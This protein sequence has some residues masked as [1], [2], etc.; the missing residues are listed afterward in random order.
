MGC[1]RGVQA[2]GSPNFSLKR[3]TTWSMV[4]SWVS[5][6]GHHGL[7]HS[8]GWHNLVLDPLVRFH[9]AGESSGFTMPRV[10]RVD[11]SPTGIPSVSQGPRALV[12]P[13]QNCLQAC[14]GF[15][16]SLPDFHLGWWELQHLFQVGAFAATLQPSCSFL[17]AFQICLIF[18]GVG[19][20][21]ECCEIPTVS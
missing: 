3:S 20:G 14:P 4:A 5:F 18:T 13:A 16:H 9:P 11:P 7:C 15:S 8:S 17:S 10:I 2:R 21:C 12:S 1:S 6:W 19:H